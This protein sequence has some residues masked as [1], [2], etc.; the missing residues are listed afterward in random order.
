M[1]D[2]EKAKANA[3]YELFGSV[4][5]DSNSTTFSS[6]LFQ[7]PSF[8]VE[9][10]PSSTVFINIYDLVEW[11]EWLYGFGLGAH[12]IGVHVYDVEYAYGA[13]D[14]GTGVVK[15]TPGYFPP[16]MWREQL[17]LGVTTLPKE[18]VETR[19]QR[20]M[21]DPQWNGTAY[22][23][24]SHNC[25]HFAETLLSLL[26]PQKISSVPVSSS[27]SR[28]FSSL[29]TKEG[30]EGNTIH[31]CSTPVITSD[32]NTS[33][34]AMCGTHSLPSLDTVSPE[35]ASMQKADFYDGYKQNAVSVAPSEI[36]PTFHSVDGS[37]GNG[38]QVAT[39]NAVDGGE[40]APTIVRAG[41]PT[42]RRNDVP[43][44]S[45]GRPASSQNFFWVPPH[46]YRL[47]TLGL[48]F[49]PMFMQ[50]WLEEQTVESN[51]AAIESG[52]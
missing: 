5:S 48:R 37:V 14:S 8:M 21:R 46:V 19:V 22:R 17:A 18:E 7:P 27:S 49:L 6:T 40:A 12:H 43:S 13:T 1:Y 39:T 45:A 30:R 20:F 38:E 34:I 3:N 24:M 10:Y 52:V 44:P 47:Q 4:S 2:S 26:Q 9:G 36:M 23:L 32:V 41:T 33:T 42:H 16:L 50:Q 15:C 25:I 29:D 31:R 11:N 51:Q 28:T 35:R